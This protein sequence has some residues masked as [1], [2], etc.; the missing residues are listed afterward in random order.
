MDNFY[1]PN[2]QEHLTFDDERPVP[3]NIIE[4][5]TVRVVLGSL[6]AGQMIPPHP[7]EKAVYQ[8]MEGEGVMTVNGEEMPVQPGT[9]IMVPSGALRALKADTRM[10]FLAVRIKLEGEAL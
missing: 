9:V 10:V 2:W 5:S 3:T 1:V 6:Q 8:F 7:E 4:D